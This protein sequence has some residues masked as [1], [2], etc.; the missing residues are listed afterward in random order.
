[1][2]LMTIPMMTTL[3][4]D[5]EH[6]LVNDQKRASDGSESCTGQR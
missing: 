5:Q 6:V 3:F 4:D 1:M 2:A